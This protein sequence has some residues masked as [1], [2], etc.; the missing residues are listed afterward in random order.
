LE[1]FKGKSALVIG[2]GTAGGGWGNG[3][4]CAAQF[5]REGASVVCFDL[6][7]ALAEEAAATIRAEGGAAVALAG[8][9]TGSKDVQAAVQAAVDSFGG[10]DLLV[11][12]V[13]IVVPGGVVEMP[14]DE[15]DRV[16]RINLKSCYLS[17]KYAIPE[18]L[19]RGG[20]SIVNI[21]SIS[22]IRYN[23]K[24]Y[25]SYYTSKAGVDHLTRVTAAEYARR[26][27]RVNAVLPGLMDTPMARISAAK[28]FGAKPEEMEA[29]WKQR[30]ERVPMG[31]MGDA[32]DIARAAAFLA[33]DDA[34]FITG[35][36]LVVDG[37]MTLSS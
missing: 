34:R 22:A 15:W 21:S 31:W 6:D 16:L 23:G 20:G 3:R 14:E 24:N 33:S 17:M 27:V 37:G 36:T 18:M 8:D 11:N 1:R 28:N 5:A 26:Q 2:A 19:K 7:G 30:A 10:L 25:A 29:L 4:A 9:A 32:F 35:Q 13:G 12:N